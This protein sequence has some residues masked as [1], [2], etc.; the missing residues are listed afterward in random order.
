MERDGVARYVA[1]L[2]RRQLPRKTQHRTGAFQWSRETGIVGAIVVT[3]YKSAFRTELQPTVR[4]RD[5]LPQTSTFN[6]LAIGATDFH[7]TA[8]QGY[9]ALLCRTFERCALQTDGAVAI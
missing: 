5:G 1:T 9:A 4:L 8:L 7:R 3:Q 2:T 6:S